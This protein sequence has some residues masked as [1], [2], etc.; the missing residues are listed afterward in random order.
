M[1]RRVFP[2]YTKADP[3]ESG[4][5]FKGVTL[6]NV[7]KFIPDALGGLHMAAIALPCTV[8]RQK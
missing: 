8:M 6:K 3:F 1:L 7:I 2:Q 4:M 5:D